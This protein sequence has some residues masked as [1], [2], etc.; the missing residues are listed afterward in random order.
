MECKKLPVQ[1]RE[2]FRIANLCST[3]EHLC[4]TGQ[5]LQLNRE[6]IIGETE[7]QL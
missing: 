7:K 4:Y 6:Y 1:N 2:G 3:V 5:T